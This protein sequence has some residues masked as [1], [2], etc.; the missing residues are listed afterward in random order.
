HVPWVLFENVPFML[1]LNGG[2]A[3]RVLTDRLER[4]GYQWAYRTVNSL[5]FGVPHRRVRVF[6]LASLEHEP[7]DVFLPDDAGRPAQASPKTYSDIGDAKLTKHQRWPHAAWG[8]RDG[9]FGSDV[10][11]WPTRR[12]FLRIDEFL[13]FEGTPLSRRASAGFLKRLK[14]STLWRPSGLV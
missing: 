1:R 12:A 8:L 10:S 6:L 13:A 9:S 3:M 14:A 7:R 11:D 4:L 2:R 5:A